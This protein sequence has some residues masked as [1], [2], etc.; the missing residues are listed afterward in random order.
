MN[1]ICAVLVNGPPPISTPA[2]AVSGVWKNPPESVAEVPRYPAVTPE[3]R[4]QP[5]TLSFEI[6][7]PNWIPAKL[8]LT[9]SEQLTVEEAV[10]VVAPTPVTTVELVL[11]TVTSPPTPRT[12][13]PPP[14]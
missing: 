1:G 9:C 13:M 3:C 8:S 4:F 12:Q 10:P 2:L 6:S 11:L 5:F 14:C 7:A